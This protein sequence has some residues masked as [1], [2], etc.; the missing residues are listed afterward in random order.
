[1]KWDGNEQL[2][3]LI[4]HAT[5]RCKLPNQEVSLPNIFLAQHWWH[6]LKPN[7]AQGTANNS[8]NNNHSKA[9]KITEHRVSG[10][11]SRD[12]RN[13]SILSLNA[14]TL[15][16]EASSIITVD[17]PARRSIKNYDNSDIDE[18]KPSRPNSY[19]VISEIFNEKPLKF[20]RDPGGSPLSL[21]TRSVYTDLLENSWHTSRRVQYSYSSS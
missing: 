8:G 5:P 10:E 18:E 12:A 19:K 4:V 17:G 11:S 3:H 20:T 21:P 14:P 16:S 1:M 13:R 2:V 7:T 15:L 9:P 6:F